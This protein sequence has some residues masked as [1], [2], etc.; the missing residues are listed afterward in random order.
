MI[1]LFRTI[2]VTDVA[3]VLR[4]NTRDQAGAGRVARQC[5]PMSIRENSPR[6]SSRSILDVVELGSGKTASPI[7][8][9]VSSDEKDVRSAVADSSP[10]DCE[11]RKCPDRTARKETVSLRTVCRLD[12]LVVPGPVRDW[13]MQPIAAYPYGKNLLPADPQA[14]Q[15][16]FRSQIEQVTHH[17]RVGHRIQ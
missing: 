10:R 16:V 12:T 11:I 8:G 6:S 9:V 5:R 7:V 14:D 17:R 13:F 3:P 15:F 2:G 1:D 4:T